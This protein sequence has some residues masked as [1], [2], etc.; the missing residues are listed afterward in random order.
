MT[1]FDRNYYR[2]GTGGFA[3]VAPSTVINS[4]SERFSEL[5]ELTR[6]S[7]DETALIGHFN[8]MENILADEVVMIPLYQRLVMVAYQTDRVAGVVQNVS[9]GGFT[10][11]IEEWFDPDTDDDGVLDTADVCLGTDLEADAADAPAG[12]KKNRLW[13]DADGNFYRG[14]GEPLPDPITVM[15]TGGCSASQVIEAAGLGNGHRK[16]GI[17]AGELESYIRS[18]GGGG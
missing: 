6:T 1:P 14:S 11:N 16:F 3:D 7:I 12:L 2:W 13:S 17:T 18:L 9:V 10:W 4:S 5:L 15:D 8:E